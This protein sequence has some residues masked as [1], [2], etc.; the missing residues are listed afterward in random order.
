MAGAIA[1]TSLFDYDLANIFPWDGTAD[2]GEP[3]LMTGC[4]WFAIAVISV[5][6][7]LYS[8]INF[9]VVFVHQ[10]IYKST[11][12][13]VSVLPKLISGDTNDIPFGMSAFFFLYN[14]LL[15]FAIPWDYLYTSFALT[16]GYRK[17]ALAWQTDSL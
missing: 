9:S 2:R 17:T 1:H 4:H 8:K 6:G 10:L 7:L 16:T 3:I 15:A 12:L 13:I 11:Y 5:F 14:F